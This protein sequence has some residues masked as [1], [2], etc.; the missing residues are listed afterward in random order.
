MKYLYL[1]ILC[2]I[3]PTISH[4]DCFTAQIR[5]GYFYPASEVFR[6]IYNDGGAEF[7]L[8]GAVHI[9]QNIDAWLNFNYFQRNG[10]S[11]GLGNRTSI[12]LYPLSTGFKY[13]YCLMDNL[14]I[15]GGLG[16]SCTWVNIHDHSSFVQQHT[17]KTQVGAVIKSGLQYWLDE[18][19]F[20][21]G[22]VDYYYSHFSGIHHSGVQPTSRNLGG[23]RI[24][25]G[26]GKS[27]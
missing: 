7:E 11:I 15:Y 18:S 4:A 22:Y 17:S 20:L 14:S 16:I 19:I 2:L 21:D 27:F 1:C 13:N 6:E 24:G 9:T 26:A 3:L 12:E 23:L 25:L 5:A 8:E 10:H